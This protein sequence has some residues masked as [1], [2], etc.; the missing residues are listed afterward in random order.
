MLLEAIALAG[1]EHVLMTATDAVVTDTE[2]VALPCGA[3]KP[4]G[5]WEMTYA[6]G[7]IMIV[8]PGITIAYDADGTASYKTRGLGK[9]EFAK[10]ADEIE[11]RWKLDGLLTQI[12]IS[13][14]RFLGLKSSHARNRWDMRNRWEP[15]PEV[16][17]F[18]AYLKR[19]FEPS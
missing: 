19:Q 15:W 2:V 9:K 11:S 16:L 5:Q 3:G 10:C 7:G 18:W 6:A 4:L 12:R 13:Q 8:Q 1:S 14:T 17:S